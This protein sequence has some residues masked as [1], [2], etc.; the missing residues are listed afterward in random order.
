MALADVAFEVH[1][2]GALGT[3]TREVPGG[4][5]VLR[6]VDPSQPGRVL[7]TLAGPSEATAG[8][9]RDLRAEAGE[10]FEILSVT[11]YS[12]VV[13]ADAP[14]AGAP[15]AGPVAAFVAA[16][17]RDVLLEPALAEGGRLRVRGILPRAMDV[18]EA[19]A[20]LQRVQQAGPWEGFRV[21]HVRDVDA[22]ALGGPAAALLEPEQEDLLR[23]ALGMGYYDTPRKCN[24]EDIAGRVGMSVSPVHKKLKEVEHALIQRHLEPDAPRPGPAKRRAPSRGRTGPAPGLMREVQVGIAGSGFA[25]ASF[26]AAHPGMRVAYQALADEAGV[27]A[28]LLVALAPPAVLQRF[29]AHLAEDPQTLGHEVLSR[30][31]EHATVKVRRRVG[32][33]KGKAAGA[34]PLAPLL[35][36]LGRDA[37]A[38][39]AVCE[40]GAVRA[41]IVVLRRLDEEALAAL[42]Q[43]L[44]Q[45][46]G[47]GGA[48]LLGV[49]DAAVEAAAL[50]PVKAEPLTGRQEEVL[51]IAHALG[52]YR[53]PRGCTL[54]DIAATLGVSANAVHKNL[55]AAEQRII[56]GH[57]AGMA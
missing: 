7:I 25:P 2:P 22:K 11:P 4:R 48:E 52:Y 55:T 45:A 49:R 51:R 43:D 44:A 31:H 56:H 23:L 50:A 19:L 10:G 26:T 18:R 5:A 15:W 54:E 39:P 16:C 12:V 57:V 53:T 34:D 6:F 17:G 30:D 32:P 47:W 41:R 9:L 3:F 46:Q 33:G 38:K 36:A 14:D 40:G 24:L 42:L 28:H 13:R 29:V 35:A 20:T 27:Q 37:W 21:V 1:A 8:V